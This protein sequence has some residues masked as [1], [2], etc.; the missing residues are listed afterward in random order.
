MRNRHLLWISLLAATLAL[1]GSCP[2]QSSGT[3]Q[4]GLSKQQNLAFGHLPLSFEVNRGQ[5]DSKVRF[6]A[7]GRGYSLFL[8]PDEAVLSLKGGQSSAAAG[9]SGS[10][11]ND[12]K[13]AANSV[14]ALKLVGANPKARVAGAEALPGNSNYF[15][16]NDP[17]RWL[18]DVPTFARVRESS[19]YPGVDVVYYGNQGQL[20]YDFAVAAGAD[21]SRIGFQVQGARKLRV[22]PTG[23][24]EVTLDG[25]ALFLKQPLAYQGSESQRRAVNVHYVSRGKN[26]FGFQLGRYHKN[27]ALVIDPAVVYSTF[28]GGSGGDVAYAVGVDSA[29]N[30][31]VGGETNSTNFP[32]VTAEQG[33]SGGNG[34]GFISKLNPTGTQLLYSTYIGGSGAD[35]VTALAVDSKGDAFVTGQT[36]SSNFPISPQSSTTSTTTAFQTIY[37]GNGDAFVTEL[38]ST[39]NMLTYSSYLGGSE[40]DFGQGIAVD[41]SGNAYITGS[42][43]SPDFPTLNPLYPTLSGSSDAFVAELNFPGTA[44]VYA[45]YLGGSQAD[46]GQSIQV[47]S[48]GNAY[49]AGYT[50]STDFPTV[51]PIQS[52]N[53]GNSDAFIS[54]LSSGGAALVFS[55]YLGGSGQDRGFGLA[56]DSSGN[57]YLAGDTQST[58]LLTTTGAFQTLYAGNGDAFAAKLT[59]SGKSLSYLTYIGGTGVDQGNA[60]AVDSSGDA[61]VVGFTE[62]SDFPKVSPF[63]SILGVTGGSTCGTGSCADA[64]VTELNPAGS[65][66]N[67]SSFLGGS[68]ADFGQAAAVDSTGNVYM[69]GSTSSANFPVI[70]GV[71]QGTLGGAA[72]NAFVAK[73]ESA[74]ASAI[75]LSPEKVNFGNE[76][77]S[78]TSSVQTVTVI[79]M[80]SA[81]LDI[82]EITPPSSD[83]TDSNDCVGTVAPSGGTCTINVSFTP[84]ATG[85]VTDQFTIT[86][87]APGSPH[88]FTVTGSGV[89]QATAVTVAPTRL[90]FPNTNVS[91]KSAAQTVTITNTG[92]ATLNITGIATTGDFSQTNTCGAK[93]NVLNVGES[94]VVSVVFAPTASGSRAGSLSIS[95]NATGSPQSVALSGNG[96]A[97]ISIA[98]KNPTISTILGSTSAT[99]TITASAVSGFTGNISLACATGVSCSFSPTTIFAGQSSTLT[100]SGLS[101]TTANPYVF[102]VTGT[103]GSQSATVNLT[104]LFESFSLVGSPALDT[105]TAGAPA[106]YTIMVTPLYGFNQQVNL[107]CASLPAGSTCSFSPGSVTPNG[108]AASSLGLTIS[109]TQT[110]SLWRWI[111][112]IP[113]RMLLFLVLGLFGTMLMLHAASKRF[114][115]ARFVVPR[116]LIGA[117][118]AVLGLL[119]LSLLLLGACRGISSQTSP[120][121]TGN[122]IITITGTLNSNTAVQETTT[123]D[124]SIT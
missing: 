54:E 72:G 30:A 27:Q 45:T 26:V 66:A 48:S 47:D 78:V 41:S 75:A 21:P 97:L 120:T 32:N 71:Y 33:S 93:L 122:Y 8:T 118:L 111:R 95:D 31:Y 92:T 76:T 101:A 36:S 18:T 62:S 43:Q 117:R 86:D 108:T 10:A 77:V 37:K 74:N 103:S 15:I 91:S 121:P 112:R 104:V 7:H 29:G 113:P 64:F 73:V 94:C 60:V 119:L 56:L 63:Q 35:S 115:A 89:T 83:F 114:S 70:A 110:A 79:N 40:A 102:A 28:L 69:A 24:L 44:L 57:I 59:A 109:T 46:T 13:Q 51:A 38:P 61:A 80:G 17:K 98:A 52:A 99:Y 107:S 58:D 116:L 19:L 6:L 65:Q 85:T 9:P 22:L 68:G 34:D 5:T 4:T 123:V 39:G 82:T 84:A 81:P 3:A 87:N 88:T 49:V 42:T 96:N 50:F 90:T 2:G 23:E 106:A 11:I 100:I 55:T 53:K 1:A 12:Q 67:Y 124:L 105:V 14:V 20:E 16:G 25:G